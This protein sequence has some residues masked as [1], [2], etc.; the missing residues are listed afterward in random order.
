MR[1]AGA[2]AGARG[3]GRKDGYMTAPEHL[4]KCHSEYQT[5]KKV[6]ILV[7]ISIIYYDKNRTL[8]WSDL[9][10]LSYRNY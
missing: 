10:C 5:W 9:T 4:L 8:N 7:L 6:F 3:R 2:G 1:Q